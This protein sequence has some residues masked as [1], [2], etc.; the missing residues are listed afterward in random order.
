MDINDEFV[1]Q[2]DQLISSHLQ[3][4][5]LT[6]ESFDDIKAKV[7]ERILTSDNYDPDKGK[8]STWLWYV[9]RSVIRNE[10]KRKSRSKDALDHETVDLD[11]I[12][13]IIGPEDAGTAGDELDRVFR[14][15]PLSVRDKR[16]VKDYHLEEYTMAELAERYNLSL[17]A[18]EQVIY[19]AMKALRQVAE[20]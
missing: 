9:V 13:N 8:I 16:M 7:Y 2:Y 12:H 10:G 14:Q 15:A 18:T 1:R 6:G 5:G 11:S 17:R 20:A 4:A 19:R 3:R